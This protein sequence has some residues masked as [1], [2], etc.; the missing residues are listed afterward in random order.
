MTEHRVEWMVSAVHFGYSHYQINFTILH[1]KTA[2]NFNFS[3]WI[4]DGDDEV[5]GVLGV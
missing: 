4:V 3:M 5:E 1:Y 2:Q